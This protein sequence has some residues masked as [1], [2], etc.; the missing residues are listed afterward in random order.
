MVV[1]QDIRKIARES[2]DMRRCLRCVMP[3]NYPGVTLDAEGVC[4]YCRTFDRYWG[5]WI[6]SPEEQARSEAKLRR[7]FEATR[8][9]NKKY[10]VLIGMSGGKDSSYMLY[11]CHKVYGLKVLTFTK[12][13][14][15]LT[16]E[17]KGRINTL[18]KAFGVKHF[19]YNDPLFLDLAG[20]FMRKTGNFCAPCE[21]ST[22]N[23]SAIIAREYDVPLLVLGSS[24]RTESSAPKHLNPWDP[25]YFGKVVKGEPYRERLRCSCYGPNYLLRDGLARL[26]GRRRMVLLP[27][28]VDWDESKIRELFSREF[29]FTF[30]GE[31]SDCWATSIA[32]YLYHL[33]MGMSPQVAKYGVLVRSGKMPREE[34]LDALSKIEDNPLPPEVDRFCRATHLTREEFEVAAGRST[35]PY[36]GGITRVFNQL[37][38][39]MRRQ[40]G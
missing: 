22:Y 16:D 24:S 30:G 17:A 29:G 23:M 14:G 27:D 18:V 32:S 26:L 36:L 10:D 31:H 35:A 39:I 12:D 6:A 21:L 7:I 2:G 5:T 15:F 4:N 1:K 3:E 9:Q 37:R 28:Y 11:L 34:A 8:R 33:K 19:Y 20:I 38:K 40:A 13:G 25:W